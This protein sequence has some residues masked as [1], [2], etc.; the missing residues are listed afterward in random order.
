MVVTEQCDSYF[1][2]RQIMRLRSPAGARGLDGAGT[3]AI[4]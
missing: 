1:L 2:T 3:I 4:N